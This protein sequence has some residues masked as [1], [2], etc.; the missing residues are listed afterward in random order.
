MLLTGT[1][2]F[3]QVMLKKK[4]WKVGVMEY[5]CPL[6]DKI[7][8][9]QYCIDLNRRLNIIDNSHRQNYIALQKQNDYIFPITPIAWRN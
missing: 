2:S 4:S 5:R 3:F 9:F 7:P 1:Y 8:L 6:D